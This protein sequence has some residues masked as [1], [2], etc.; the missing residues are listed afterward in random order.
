MGGAIDTPRGPRRRC[1]C[2]PHVPEHLSGLWEVAGAPF[3]GGSR[4]MGRGAVGNHR[5]VGIF[6]GRVVRVALN[7]WWTADLTQRYW[8]EITHREDVGGNLQSPKLPEGMW[9]YDL[10]SQVQPGDRV[11]HWKSGRDRALVGWSDVVGAP[12]TVPQY[13]WQPRGTSGRALSG[14]RTT[15]GW[16]APLGGMTSFATQPTLTSLLPLLD[17][18]MDLDERLANEHRRPT[19]FPFYRYGGQQIRTQQAYFVKFPVELFNVIPGIDAARLGMTA[20]SADDAEIAE[21]FQP[22]KKRAPSG[23]TTRAQDPKLRAAI[24]RRSL[25]VATAYYEGIGG[26]DLRELGKPYDI[27]VTVDGVERHCE[28]KGSSMLIDTVELTA[29]EVDHGKDCGNVDLIVVDG[30]DISRDRATGDI[31]AS[32]GKLRVWAGWTPADESLRATKFAYSLP[33]HG[34]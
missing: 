2:D 10:V 5:R 12:T 29:N 32:G 28:V 16:V 15:P 24:E 8:M 17:E 3:V 25:D 6:C 9:S 18:L 1:R 26:T 21:D 22:R 13:T 30:I 27:A 14:P 11:L 20:A 33:A 34:G 23:R 7:S 19:Y 4:G 31:T